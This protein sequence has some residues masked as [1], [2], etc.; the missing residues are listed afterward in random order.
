MKLTA[1]L[2]KIVILKNLLP[3]TVGSLKHSLNNFRNYYF[4]S[5]FDFYPT[6][7]YEKSVNILSFSYNPS[8]CC[9]ESN[10]LAFC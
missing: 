3:A 4:E 5:I 8:K 10:S 6:H 1:H 9:W 7:V 2:K